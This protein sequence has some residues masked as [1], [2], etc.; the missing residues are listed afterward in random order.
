MI[1]LLYKLITKNKFMSLYRYA[2]SSDH[3]QNDLEWTSRERF[4]WLSLDEK[5]VYFARHFKW[6]VNDME[7]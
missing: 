2:L 6:L 5:V 1:Q 7:F 4:K 3:L